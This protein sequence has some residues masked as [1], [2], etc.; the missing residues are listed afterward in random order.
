MVGSSPCFFSHSTIFP[1]SCSYRAPRYDALTTVNLVWYQ[2]TFNYLN[3][4]FALAAGSILTNYA[5]TPELAKFGQDCALHNDLGLE[6]VYFGIDVWAQNVQHGKQKRVTWPRIGGG[7]TGTGLGVQALKQ[8]GLNAGIFAPG[9]SFEHFS[10][11][12]RTIERAIWDGE[13]MPKAVICE[14][15]PGSLHSSVAYEGH[16]IGRSVDASPAGSASFMHMDFRRAFTSTSSE[17]TTAHIGAQSVLPQQWTSSPGQHTREQQNDFPI[18]LRIRDDP[19]RA[20]ASANPSRPESAAGVGR[21]TQRSTLFFAKTNITADGD[22]TLRIAYRWLRPGVPGCM[23]YISAQLKGSERDEH[24]FFELPRIREMNSVEYK[25]Q[26]LGNSNIVRVG[27]SFEIPEESRGLDTITDVLEL[28]T[29]TVVPSAA[30]AIRCAIIDTRLEQRT[31]RAVPHYRLI[32]ALDEDEDTRLGTS[33]PWSNITGPC[34]HFLISIDGEEVGRAYALEFVLPQKVAE[35]WELNAMFEVRIQGIGFDG[36]VLVESRS[37]L[38]WSGG[39]DGEW[40]MI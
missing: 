13:K 31:A 36:L 15:G 3:L 19:P 35:R 40:L 7:G 14:C 30:S 39:R 6:N 32:W 27:L 38:S 10:E 4:P 37:V 9:W 2:N 26:Q 28:Y 1:I 29:I 33:L 21:K 17:R 25:I 16:G 5:W 8:A 24:Q 22:N 18:N 23:A 20:I 34:S 11:H 12:N